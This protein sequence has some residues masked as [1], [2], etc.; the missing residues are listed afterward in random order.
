MNEPTITVRILK[1]FLDVRQTATEQVM[2]ESIEPLIK[3]R[4]YHAHAT[5]GTL[6]CEDI[7]VESRV[8]VA[9]RG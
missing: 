6:L 5:D 1:S 8:P 4:T 2:E 7:V 9:V 3:V